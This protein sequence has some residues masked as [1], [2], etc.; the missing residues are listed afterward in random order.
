MI[1]ELSLTRDRFRMFVL[2]SACI[3][4]ISGSNFG[5]RVGVC[6]FGKVLRVHNLFPSPAHL[7]V[8]VCLGLYSDFALRLEQREARN[9][10]AWKADGGRR[11]TADFA[12]D[13]STAHASA[14]D[15]YALR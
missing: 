3:V 10:N 4:C 8:H 2:Q 15:T 13:A 9:G 7:P 12:S 6:V 11:S 14:V 1:L 5:K